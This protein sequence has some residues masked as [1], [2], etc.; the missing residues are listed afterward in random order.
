MVI[1]GKCERLGH[2]KSNCPDCH[3][4]GATNCSFFECPKSSTCSATTE[5]TKVGREPPVP[6]LE[7]P[8][9]EPAAFTSAR[10]PR[11]FA[12][13]DLCNEYGEREVGMATPVPVII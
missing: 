2:G 12:P 4:C 7:E 1:R 9:Q 8:G 3:R 13:I 10:D 5:E 11:A 6:N